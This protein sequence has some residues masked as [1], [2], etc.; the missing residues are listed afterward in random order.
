MLKNL[1]KTKSKLVKILSLYYDI[2]PFI[3]LLKQI[4]NQYKFTELNYKLSF[5]FD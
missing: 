3:S 4:A 5:R 1:L 2:T